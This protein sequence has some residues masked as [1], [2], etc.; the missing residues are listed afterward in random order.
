MLFDNIEEKVAVITKKLSIKEQ[1]CIKD[2]ENFLNSENINTQDFQIVIDKMKNN[3]LLENAIVPEA[4]NG[5][6]ISF[7]FYLNDEC[8]KFDYNFLNMPY[9]IFKRVDFVNPNNND[10]FFSLIYSKSLMS[11]NE[12]I[13]HGAV[14]RRFENID[15]PLKDRHVEYDIDIDETGK[16]SEDSIYITGG[17]KKL[18][19]NFILSEIDQL[20]HNEIKDLL[21]LNFDIDITHNKESVLQHVFEK[22]CKFQNLYTQKETELKNKQKNN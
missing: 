12:F 22:I 21:R 17:K 2:F 4:N 9:T 1:N 15:T 20:N 5:K 6:F 14:L 7:T 16:V 3:Q 10:D 13:Y 18:A 11:D 19:L 8:I